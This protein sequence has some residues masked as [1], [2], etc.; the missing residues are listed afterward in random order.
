[1]HAKDTEKLTSYR[2]ERPK[3]YRRTIRLSTD[4][5]DSKVCAKFENG[6]N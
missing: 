3:K 5:D 6:N 1:M 4:L 2:A